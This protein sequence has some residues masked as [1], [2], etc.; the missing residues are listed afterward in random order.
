[1]N[2]TSSPKIVT[3][4]QLR[5]LIGPPPRNRKVIMCHGVFDIVHPG[6]LRHL[7][8]AKSKAD[9]LVA[10]LTADVHI[11]KAHHRPYVPQ[12]LRAFNLA[13]FEFVDYVVIDLN[14]T[15]IENIRTIQPD[16]FAKGYEYYTKG[17]P[18]RTKEEMDT[19]RAYGGEM[20]FTPGDVV[21]SSSAIIEADPP[22]LHIEKLLAL[23]ESENIRFTDLYDTIRGFPGVKVH[24]VGDTIVDTYS[25]CSLLGATAKSPTF[26]VRF[27]SSETYVGGAAV[28]AKHMRAAGADVTFTTVLGNDPN[29]QL[30]CRD[31]E[32]AGIRVDTFIDQTRVTTLKERFIADNFKMLQVD[33]LDNRVISEE[34]L[35]QFGHSLT[36]SRGDI[37]VFSDFRHGIFNRQTISRLTAAIRPEA[38]KVADSQVSNRWGNILDFRGFD[39]L[40]PNERE[41]RFALADQDSVVRPLASELFRQARCKYLILKLGDRG[42]IG[43]RSPGPMPRE[44]FT[45]DSFVDRLVD[46]IGAG[47]A[48][49]AYA[50]MALRRT[51]NIVIAS[52]L[53]SLGAAVACEWQGNAPVPLNLV[54]QKLEA[55]E[56]MIHYE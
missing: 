18:A 6:H 9:V 13:A 31:L 54:Q 12:E 56:R 15:P 4:A 43:Y 55:V 17:V 42:I 26:S 51:D 16:Y 41:A 5:E 24:V 30:V 38:L 37:V 7:S 33:R 19:V 20:L 8:Y 27:D 53:G 34:C 50:S 21:Y 22:R 36:H 29:G 52:I 3:A 45:V 49:L 28:V 32:A 1:M 10:S 39:L 44:F 46:P 2:M 11:L 40:T 23:L 48:L 25:Y 47:D 35:E 14:A